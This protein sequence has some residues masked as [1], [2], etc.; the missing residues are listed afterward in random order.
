MRKIFS[1]TRVLLG[2]VVILSITSA[3]LYMDKLNTRNSE[4]FLYE[5]VPHI[6]LSNSLSFDRTGKATGKVS[7]FVAF[8]NTSD[9]PRGLSQYYVI[10]PIDAYDANSRQVFVYDDIIK[11]NYIAPTN[12]GREILVVINDSPATLTLQ[13]KSG[14]LFKID[15]STKSVSM[16]DNTNDSTYLITSSGDY[17]NFKLNLLKNR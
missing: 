7:G 6:A 1:K 14:N 10:E 17:K 4:I 16:S 13:D 12:T 9:Q 11:M 8:K 2:L 3:S 15:K 5:T